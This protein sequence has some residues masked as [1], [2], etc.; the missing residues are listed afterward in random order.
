MGAPGLS[1]RPGSQRPYVSQGGDEVGIGGS[2]FLIALGA[3]LAFAVNA[4]LGWLDV[5]VVGWVMMIA[6]LAGLILTLWFWNSRRRRT[7]RTV[8]R[9]GNVHTTTDRVV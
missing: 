1:G 3:I 7:V 9:A 2:I 5:N 4:S 8:D 6:G